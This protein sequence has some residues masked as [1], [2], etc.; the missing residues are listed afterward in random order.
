MIVM[1]GPRHPR[2]LRPVFRAGGCLSLV[3]VPSRVDPCGGA[4]EIVMLSAASRQWMVSHTGSCLAH[5]TG[6]H[7]FGHIRL[8]LACAGWTCGGSG[9]GAVLLTGPDGTTEGPKSPVLLAWGGDGDQLESL[10]LKIRALP[11]AHGT[12]RE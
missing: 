6:R 7:T 10:G 8:S 11:V 5:P 3:T 1:D 4:P 12:N 9:H 2:I